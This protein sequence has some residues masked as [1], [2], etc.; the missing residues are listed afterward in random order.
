MKVNGIVKQHMYN[1]KAPYEPCFADGDQHIVSVSYWGCNFKCQYCFWH[2][3]GYAT[4]KEEYSMDE[5]LEK[6]DQIMDNYP[7]KA[8]IVTGAEPTCQDSLYDLLKEAK[9]RGLAVRIDTN[10]S[11]PDMLEKLLNE[12]LVD[13]ITLDIKAPKD[14]YDEVAGVKVNLKDIEKS[15]KLTKKAPDYKF[16]TVVCH[17]LVGREELEEILNWV[18]DPKH[19]IKNYWDG[20]EP[21]VEKETL[22]KFKDE[23]LK[24]LVKGLDAKIAPKMTNS[25]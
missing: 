19:E 3:L 16:R 23:E 10:G 7:V 13:F 18:D 12:K 5:I 15:I 4:R 22:T 24:D 17:E 20:N 1:E 2:N 21:W 9:K 6:I 14:M 8:L 25:Y 11:N